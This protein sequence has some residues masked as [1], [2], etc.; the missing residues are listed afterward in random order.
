MSKGHYNWQCQKQHLEVRSRRVRMEI[1]PE[2]EEVRSLKTH[3]LSTV[4][5]VINW[6]EGVPKIVLI[7][8]TK[9]LAKKFFLNKFGHKRFEMSLIVSSTF[10]SS[11]LF[12][13]GICPRLLSYRKEKHQSTRTGLQWHWAEEQS[14]QNTQRERT[15]EFDLAHMF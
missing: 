7:Q 12:S 4:F 8:M 6:L 11:A 9:K 5:W 14:H 10:G 2:S 13:K 1:E 15:L 3:S